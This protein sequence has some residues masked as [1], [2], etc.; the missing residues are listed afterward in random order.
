MCEMEPFSTT[1]LPDGVHSRFVEHVNGLRVH[2]LTAG[3]PG[4]PLLLLLHGFPELAYS[5]RKIMVPLADAGYYV[6]APDQ[7]GYGRTAG[8]QNGYDCD[9]RSFALLNIVRDA[10]ALVE[11][12]GYERTHALIGHDFG[13]IAAAWC[14]LIRPDHFPAVTLMSAPFGGPPRWEEAGHSDIHADLLALDRPRKHYQWY[15][16]TRPAEADMLFAPQGLHSFLRAYYH[17]KS[18]DW[19]RNQPYRLA[20][21]NAQELAKLPTYYVMDADANMAQTVATFMPSNAAIVQCKWLLDHEL[22]IYTEEFTRTGLQGGLNHYRCGIS[23]WQKEELRLFAGRRIDVPMAYISGAADW[24]IYQAPGAF[25]A[26]HGVSC[27]DMRV[28]ELI[29]GAGH[30]VQQERPRETVN[31]LLT[32]LKT[33][34]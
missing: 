3:N 28:C 8:W 5:W 1:V 11:R 13:S 2:T 10:L 20:E 34:G 14:A 6:V 33:L 25:E 29:P 23:Q 31:T 24:G 12:L 9:L 7:R 32:F 26:M 18:A 21:W 30:W 4:R 15:Y 27:S 19:T 17:V 22:S 16:S